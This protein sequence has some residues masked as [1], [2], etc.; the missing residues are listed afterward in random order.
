MG[1]KCGVWWNAKITQPETADYVICIKQ[2]K[3]G[4]QEMC[5]GSFNRDALQWD[6]EKRDFVKGP[7]IWRTNGGNNNVI[8]W[9][10]L[11][12]MPEEENG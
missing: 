8:W 2:L 3:N 11:P 5:L 4:R 10:E 6:P 9:T 7:G 12:E 1:V